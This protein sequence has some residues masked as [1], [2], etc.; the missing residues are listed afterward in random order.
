[1]MASLPART[2]DPPGQVARDDTS[3]GCQDERRRHL[4][5]RHS[6]AGS[7]RTPPT[8]WTLRHRPSRADRRP[9]RAAAVLLVTL[10]AVSSAPTAASAASA[11][12]SGAA[13]PNITSTYGSG[14]FGQWTIDQFGLPSYR[15]TRTSAAVPEAASPE[16]SA[17]P[18]S[19]DSVEPGRQRPRRGRPPRPVPPPCG[20]SA[21]ATCT[22]KR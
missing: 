18:D 8:F 17:R 9:P 14:D 19:T 21:S 13:S 3:H 7:D 1:M 20:T 2:S 12:P 5:S 10:L 22:A 11:Q 15:Y 4:R 16:L 6:M